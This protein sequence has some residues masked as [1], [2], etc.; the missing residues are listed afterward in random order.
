VTT[1]RRRTR[2][3]QPAFPAPS[4]PAAWFREVAAAYDDAREAIAFGPFVGV[5]LFVHE[6]FHLAPAVCLKFRGLPR[7]NTAL[8]RATD[9]A[10]SSYVAMTGRDAESLARLSNPLMAF[11]FCYVA[12]HFGLDLVSEGDAAEAL[13][14][15]AR[16][17]RATPRPRPSPRGSA[18]GTHLR[19]VPPSRPEGGR[20]RR[21]RSR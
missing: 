5:E 20:T 8:K 15:V 11:A 17:L 12:A 9:A 21:A 19:P 2:S 16:R 6:L 18:S 1:R 13:D 10:L 4:T 7:S 3:F 14:Y